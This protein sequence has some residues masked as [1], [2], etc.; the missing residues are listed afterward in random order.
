MDIDQ[1]R[2]D[3]QSATAS[4]GSGKGTGVAGKWSGVRDARVESTDEDLL[5]RFCTSDDPQAYESLVEQLT[6][7]SVTRVYSVVVWGIPTSLN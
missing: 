7:R 3:A 6:L 2:S 4:G 1:T 5:Q